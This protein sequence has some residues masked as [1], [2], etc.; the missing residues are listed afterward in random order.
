MLRLP[1]QYFGRFDRR[2]AL[3]NSG[4]PS[5][6]SLVVISGRHHQRSLR[7]RG[8]AAVHTS[9]HTEGHTRKMFQEGRRAFAVV[10]GAGRSL[11]CRPR[12]WRSC[13]EEP[14]GVAGLLVGA[15][16]HVLGTFCRGA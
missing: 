11:R 8:E 2:P 1:F 5:P 13:R 10:L 12:G 6:R 4:I 16:H 7:L 9:G 3:F 15:G 14:I